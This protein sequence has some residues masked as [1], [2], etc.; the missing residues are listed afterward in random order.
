MSSSPATHSHPE[1]VDELSNWLVGGGILTAA[2][3]PL[4]LPVL[5][6]TAAAA[7]ASATPLVVAVVAAPILLLR[8]LGRLIIR[9][10]HR[11]HP[12]TTRTSASAATTGSTP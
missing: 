6:L 10:L 5:L 9:A 4:A 12:S 3:F 11:T 2:L 1:P 7:R 8:R